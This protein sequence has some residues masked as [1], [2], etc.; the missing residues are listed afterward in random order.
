MKDK[1]YN[2][3]M[4]KDYIQADFHLKHLKRIRYRLMK[5]REAYNTNNK[6]FS[7]K[8]ALEKLRKNHS[9]SDQT[10]DTLF[11]PTSNRSSIDITAV[12]YLCQLLDLDIAQVLA[13]PEETAIDLE[14]PSKYNNFVNSHFKMLDDLSYDGTFYFYIFR[15]SGTDSSFRQE[16]PDSLCKAEDLIQGELVFD[17]KEDSGSTAT[18]SYE[19]MVPQLDRSIIPI[20]KTATCIPMVSTLNDNVYLNF[21]DNDSKAY[22]IVFDKQKFY[23]GACYF[24]IAGMFIESSDSK[25]LPLFQKML[26]VRTPLQPEQYS[27]IKGI[28]NLNQETIIISPKKLLDLAKE[29]HEIEKF[30]ECYGQKMDAYK[31]ELLVFN[32]NMILSDD[33]EM[34]KESRTSVLLKIWHHTFSQNSLTIAG[35]DDDHK[36]FKKLQQ[37]VEQVESPDE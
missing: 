36:I 8:N 23:S 29:D 2:I 11:D 3:L 15:Y 32:K 14:E 34:S 9:I 31:K 22:Q 4:D 35:N 17:I 7:R 25:H 16:Y 18:L 5:G 37:N 1:N 6:K 21:V 24:R 26:L 10:F 27:Y 19:Q 33:S 12:V 13:F 30:V 20:K 28:L